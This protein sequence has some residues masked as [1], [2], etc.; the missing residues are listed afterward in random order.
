MVDNEKQR[1][2]SSDKE[3]VDL[4]RDT[5]LRFAGCTPDYLSLTLSTLLCEFVQYG[6]SAF[7]S[8]AMHV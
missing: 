8:H 6:N 7:L 3:A 4:F 2:D 5:Q 1:I